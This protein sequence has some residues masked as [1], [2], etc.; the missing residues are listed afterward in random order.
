MFLALCQGCLVRNCHSLPVCIA[1]YKEKAC[2]RNRQAIIIDPVRDY[3]ARAKRV[4]SGEL[5][6]SGKHAPAA[7]AS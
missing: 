3:Y 5:E 1:L 2:R 6:P 7:Y 4:N